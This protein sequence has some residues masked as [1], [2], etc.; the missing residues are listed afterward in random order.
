[1]LLGYQMARGC[2]GRR[3]HVTWARG[4]VVRFGVEIAVLCPMLGQAMW[5]M[6]R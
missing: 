5:R 4:A 2:R 1:M 3:S 6:E